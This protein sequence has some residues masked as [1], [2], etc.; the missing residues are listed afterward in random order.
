MPFFRNKPVLDQ[1]PLLNRST[2]LNRTY[3]PKITPVRFEH[4]GTPISK[5]KSQGLEK[6]MASTNFLEKT[7]SP[8]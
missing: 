5:R 7:K 1:T 3:M 4:S 8:F 2:L 6:I